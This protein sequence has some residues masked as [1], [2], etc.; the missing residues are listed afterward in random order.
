MRPEPVIQIRLPIK[1]AC[2]GYA[3]KFRSCAKDA[4]LIK[5]RLGKS[6]VIRRC[7]GTHMLRPACAVTGA[8]WRFDCD[9]TPSSTSNAL[10]RSPRRSYTSPRGSGRHEPQRGT[11][12]FDSN[13][14][15]PKATSASVCYTRGFKSLL[16]ASRFG[17]AANEAVPI[18]FRN[19]GI[20][21]IPRG[22]HQLCKRTIR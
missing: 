3:R 22:S 13:S 2:A 10:Q 16:E 1:H 14:G 17:K 15:L 18:N 12:G 9:C 6:Q 4:S 8:V 7:F 19:F 11:V 5:K 20:K 21:A